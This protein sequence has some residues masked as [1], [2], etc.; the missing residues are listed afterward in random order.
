[1]KGGEGVIILEKLLEC[2]GQRLNIDFWCGQS[3]WNLSTV[4][5]QTIYH[6]TSVPRLIGSWGNMGDDSAEILF[7]SFLQ[8]A[9]MNSSNMGRNVHSDTVHPAFPVL[10]K[11]S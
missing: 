11:V 7:G 5:L 3:V 1:M 10:I 8:E 2:I 9:I 4:P 6:F